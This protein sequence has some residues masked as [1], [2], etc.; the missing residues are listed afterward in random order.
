MAKNERFLFHFLFRGVPPSS[1]ENAHKTISHPRRE[2][3]SSPHL[4][5]FRYTPR[6]VSGN[7]KAMGKKGN[8]CFFF[9]FALFLIYFPF[10]DVNAHTH[11]GEKCVLLFG[12]K[13]EGVLVL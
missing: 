5:I 4:Y 9:F 1:L 8:F 10:A 12:G 2:G 13:G 3:T 6:E 11:V 7:N